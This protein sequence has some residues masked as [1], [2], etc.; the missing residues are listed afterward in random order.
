MTM[1]A[2]RCR[3]PKEAISRWPLLGTSTTA[4]YHDVLR[5]CSECGSVKLSNMKRN[6]AWRH[7]ATWENVT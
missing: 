6:E 3:H 7:P 4:K 2:K 1:K 5:W